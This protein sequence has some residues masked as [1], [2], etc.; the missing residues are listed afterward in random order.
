MSVRQWLLLPVSVL[1]SVA[2]CKGGD[3]VQEF[4]EQQASCSCSMPIYAT[5]EDCE[6]SL[7]G[8]TDMLKSYAQSMGLTFNQGCYDRSFALFADVGCATDFTDSSAN[9]SY[10]AIIHGDK[11]AGAACTGEGFS[12]CGS[13]LFC[14]D[15]VCLDFCD[16]QKPLNAGDVCA[17]QDGDLT[18]SVGSCGNG[19]YCDYAGGTLTCTPLKGD[20]EACD[21]FGDNCKE[22]LVCGAD[23]T[24]G[25]PP[26]EGEACTSS[27]ATNLVCDTG[28]CVPAPGEGS[29]CTQ[30][31]ECADGLDCG[32][33]DVC[34]APEPL[35][36]GIG[37][38]D[39]F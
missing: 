2:A 17:K 29:P 35:V 5:V 16:Q 15:G 31:G 22:G 18:T 1:L 33:N 26:A 28:S 21:T 37:G 12:D 38:D 3:P 34:A 23:S 19:L 27:C 36:C 8:Q 30:F 9:C 10:C 11:P 6:A 4:C 13:N 7:N 20:G 39:G 25:P 32:D 14:A 24:C